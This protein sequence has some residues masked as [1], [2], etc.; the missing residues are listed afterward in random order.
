M[1]GIFFVIY[2]TTVAKF[3]EV[4]FS[5]EFSVGKYMYDILV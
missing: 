5:V 4:S 2:F 1:A 3:V